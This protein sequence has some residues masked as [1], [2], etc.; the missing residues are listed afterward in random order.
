MD[1]VWVLIIPLRSF[2]ESLR[3]AERY[4]KFDVGQLKSV[5]A[6]SIGRTE[7]DVVDIRKLAEGGY[8]RTFEITM[9]DGLQVIARLPYPMTLPK[10]YATASE[11]ATMDYV[12]LHGIP[13]PRIHDYSTTSE[14]LVGSEYIIMEKVKGKE[15]GE[16]WFSM[17]SEERLKITSQIVKLETLLFSIKLPASGSIY[18]RRDLGPQVESVDIPG[19]GEGEGFCIGRTLSNDG[20]RSTK[21]VLRAV[22]RRELTWTKYCARPRFPYEALYREIYDYQKVYPTDHIKILSDYMQ[23]AEY[24]GPKE[25]DKLGRPVLRHADLQPNNL[26]V[27]DSMDLLGVIDWQLCSVLPLFLHT[28]LPN[29]FQHFNDPGFD[30]LVEP[31]L[32]DNFAELDVQEQDAARELFRRR[33]LHYFY[34]DLTA[35]LNRDHH[36]AFNLDF[37]MLRKL[38]FDGAGTPWEGDNTTL[39]SHL[40]RANEVWPLLTSAED[41]SDLSCPITY[42]PE[43]TERCL[44]LNSQQEEV[45]TLMDKARRCLGVNI[46]GWL[47]AEGYNAAKQLSEEWKAEGIEGAEKE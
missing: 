38:L 23:I 39:K 22:G 31:R 40:I 29:H 5:A 30:Q 19:T 44:D 27:S 17:T 18:Y 8:N 21:D 13:V 35:K 43:E 45:Q 24:I 10:N 42:D 25:G 33:Q 16:S 12:R 4:S 6:T 47:P 37:I 28:G 34:I 7:T 20:V 36:D 32:P 41:G 2:N 46:Q 3:L 9:K 15:L 14:N 11:V 26:F 1:V